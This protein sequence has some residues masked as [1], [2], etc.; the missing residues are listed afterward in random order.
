[1]SDLLINRLI[2]LENN[3]SLVSERNTA[4][5]RLR[6]GLSHPGLRYD[7]FHY[8][9]PFVPEGCSETERLCRYLVAGLFAF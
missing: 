8:V 9:E 5:A 3:P 4:F 1:M 2:E 7:T 6:R